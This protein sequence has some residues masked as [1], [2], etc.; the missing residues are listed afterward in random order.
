MDRYSISK[1]IAAD[2]NNIRNN[3]GYLKPDIT[4]DC[5]VPNDLK[6]DKENNISERESKK[7]TYNKKCIFSHSQL[8]IRLEDVPKDVLR[9][10]GFFIEDPDNKD[11][12]EP[13]K[14]EIDDDEEEDDN[15]LIIDESSSSK[16]S[17][18]IKSQST[19]T[20]LT[21]SYKD[22]DYKFLVTERKT[23]HE[24]LHCH[25]CFKLLDDMKFMKSHVE[26]H[27]DFKGCLDLIEN[28]AD[29]AKHNKSHDH[30]MKPFMCNF[31]KKRFHFYRHCAKHRETCR[32]SR[33]IYSCSYCRVT[34]SKINQ[35]N[36]HTAKHENAIICSDCTKPFI[37]WNIYSKHLLKIHNKQIVYQCNRCPKRFQYQDSMIQH[38]KCHNLNIVDCNL[39]HFIKIE[40]VKK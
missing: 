23:V 20:E 14:E 19:N 37:T 22:C 1:N 5:N 24:L 29:R 26:K 30:P 11:I 2:S 12:S 28:E 4:I 7:S 25:K 21:C 31:C 39:S 9:N 3:L 33:K 10:Y 18:P 27:C 8:E 36:K 15:K 40:L 32:D 16:I 34:F 6:S 17:P 13:K 38:I 35:F